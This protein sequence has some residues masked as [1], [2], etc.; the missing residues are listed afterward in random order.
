[1]L[2]IGDLRRA[3]ADMPA[4]AAVLL[5]VDMAV[6]L[7]NACISNVL[8][9]ADG[10]HEAYVDGWYDVAEVNEASENEFALVLGN[11]V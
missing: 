11:E 8:M 2:K 4:D 10:Q 9:D 5:R 7:T 6:P 1:M 3:I